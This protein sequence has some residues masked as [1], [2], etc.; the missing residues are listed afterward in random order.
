MELGVTYIPWSK[1][2][3][4]Q[5][6]ELKEGGALDGDTLSPGEERTHSSSET[7]P[8]FIILNYYYYFF[9]KEWSGARK[10][11]GNIEE[12]THN[13]GSEL[14]LPEEAQVLPAAA[15]PAQ[16]NK[17]LL[18]VGVGGKYEGPFLICGLIS[19]V[20]CFR[21]LR[22]SHQWLGSVLCSRRSFPVP[23][24]YLRLPSPPVFHRHPSS[25]PASIPCKCLQ[26]KPSLTHLGGS[27]HVGLWVL[28]GLILN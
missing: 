20:L 23:S 3:E 8:I 28:F 14:Q 17:R 27:C 16:V 18:F 15:P 1:L 10:M 22:C 6:E 12:L 19:P 4:D 25:G 24:A 11:L 21:F 5:L 9:F 13:G 26:V 7:S 2:R